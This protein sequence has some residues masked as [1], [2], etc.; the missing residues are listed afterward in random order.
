ML[1]SGHDKEH[2]YRYHG[3]C[4]RQHGN[5]VGEGGLHLGLEDLG[6]FHVQRQAVEQAVQDTRGFTGSDQIAIECIKLPRVP[7][8]RCAQG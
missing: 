6:F 1:E 4:Y 2:D 7:A 8:K 5:R 3:S